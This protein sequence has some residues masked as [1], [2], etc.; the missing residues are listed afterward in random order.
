[1]SGVPS[2]DVARSAFATAVENREPVDD[3]TSLTNDHEQVLFFTELTGFEGQTISHRWEHG[4][5]VMAEIPFEVR[6]QRWRVWSTK[7][8][9]PGW[10]GTWSVS[11][12]DGA[13]RVLDSKQLSFVAAQAVPASPAPA[14]EM[15]E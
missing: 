1:M 7:K 3:L 4:G 13:G 6:G 2:G 12:I 9:Q 5:E 10:T 14:A 15:A 11:V 8:L